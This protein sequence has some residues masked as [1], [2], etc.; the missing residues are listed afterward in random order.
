MLDV[1]VNG[2]RT[3]FWMYVPNLENRC[4]LNL[5]THTPANS[6]VIGTAVINTHTLEVVAVTVLCLRK[7]YLR[8]EHRF[9]E[10]RHPPHAAMARGR[11]KLGHRHFSA[12]TAG[13]WIPHWKRISS[14]P[15]RE[16]STSYPVHGEPSSCHSWHF[17]CDSARSRSVWGREAVATPQPAHQNCS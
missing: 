3:Y 5:N 9:A 10:L 13:P 17:R 6:F 12:A 8:S 16:A 7:N 14:R 15:G 2:V 4:S 11:W 1:S